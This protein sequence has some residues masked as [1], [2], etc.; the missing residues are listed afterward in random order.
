MAGS[1]YQSDLIKLY[2]AAFI[3]A[4]ERSGLDYW[5]GQLNSGKSFDS[6]LETVFSLDIV[7]SI[8]PEGLPNDS[9]VTL[10][11]VNVFGKAPDLEGLKYW[12]KQLANGQARGNLVMDMINT[13]LATVD[14]TPGK[15]YISNRL[16]VAEFAV[17][18]QNFQRADFTP[19]YLKSIMATVNADNSTVTSANAAMNSSVTGIGL[20]APLNAISI[21]VATNG[22]SQAE[23][24]AGV[25]VSVDLTGTNAVAGNTVELLIDQSSFSTPVTKVLTAA[26]VT[27]KKVSLT[28][29]GTNSWGSDGSKMLS[30]FVK[31]GK[32]GVGLAGG[33]IIVNLDQTAPRAPN[34][35]VTVAAATNGIS[36]TEKAAGVEV[37]VDLF[38]TNA[39]AGDKLELMLNG[40]TLVP[41][42]SLVL[43][44]SDIGNGSAKLLIAAST[45]WGAD[46][47]KTIGARLTDV[48]GNVGG[49]GGNL[50][51]VLDTTAPNAFKNTISIDAAAGGIGPLERDS[52]INVQVSLTGLPLVVGDSLE[53]LIDGRVFSQSTVKS[54]T[55][56]DI[57]AGKMNL[58]IGPGDTAWG[59]VDGDHVIS[60]RIIDAAGNQGVAGGDLKVTV[61]SQA[62][63]SQNLSVS[64]PSAANGLSSAEIAAGVDVVVSLTGSG[65][66]VGDLLTLYIDGSP[67]T[68][69]VSQALTAA[70][71]SAKAAILKV[72]NTINWGGDGVKKISANLRDAAGNLGPTSPALSVTID[73]VAPAK[74]AN[75]PTIAVAESN[76]NSAE[77]TAGVQVSVDITNTGALVGDQIE[78]LIDGKSFTSPVIQVLQANDV[79]TNKVTLTVS[80]A[81][82][83]IDG[84]KDI[85][86]RVIDV[87]GNTGTPSTPVNVMLDTVAPTG[88]STSLQ[89]PANAGGGLTPAERASG[90]VVTADLTGTGAV[91]GD[92]IEILIGGN[93]FA[94]PAKRVLTAAEI[95]AHLV[96]ITIGT[97]DGWIGTGSKDLT[98]RF[99]DTSGN[100]GS[101]AGKV[102]VNVLAPAAVSTALIVPAAIGGINPL[103]KATGVN[104]IVNLGNT[105]VQPG[106]AVE[107]LI[108]GKPFA[109]STLHVLSDTEIAVGSI[110]LTIAGGDAGWGSTDGDKSLSARIIDTFG[111]VGLGGGNQKVTVDSSSPSSQNLSLTMP[112]ALNGLNASEVAAGV[113]VTIGLTGTGVVAGD[114]VT[115][116]LGGSPFSSNVSLVLS[117][118]QVTAKSAV[119]TIPPTVNWGSDGNKILSAYITDAAGNQGLPGGSL[120]VVLDTSVPTAPQNPI[121]IP[122]AAQN[123]NSLE[124]LAGVSVIVDLT[125]SGAAAGDKLEVLIGGVP[126]ATPISQILS[127]ADINNHLANILIP[128]TAVWGSDGIKLISARVIDIAG[129]LGVPSP[130][131]S[132]NLDTTAPSSPAVQLQVPANAGGGIDPTERAAGVNVIVDLTGTL[133]TVGDTVEILNGGLPFT[134]PVTHV[135]TLND[136]ILRT[137]GLTIGTA[138]GW[139]SDGNKIL[140]I[141]FVDTSGNV[142]IPGGATT[143]NLDGTP[144]GMTATQLTVPAATNGINGTEITSGVV[145]NVDLNGTN[146]LAG[147]TVNILLNG[148]AFPTPVRQVLSSAQ[149]TAKTAAVTIP[150][151]AGWGA[152]GNKTLSASVTDVLGNVGAAGGAVIVLVDTVAPS[153]PTNSVSIPMAMNGISAAEKSSG[154][155]VL[156]DL[157]GTNAVVGDKLELLI[158]GSAFTSPVSVTLN[159]SHITNGVVNLTIPSTAGWGADASKTISARVIDFA[160]NVGIGG[161]GVTAILDTTAPNAPSSSL[162]VPANGGGGVTAAEKNAGI[163]V[164]VSLSGANVQAG[165]V[166]DVL[167]GGLPFTTPV[168]HVLTA[169]EVA[170]NSVTLNIGSG[171]GWGADGAKTLTARFTDVAG[172]V[173]A[174]GGS[175]TIT[176]LDTTPPNAPSLSLYVPSAVG[177]I[178]ASEK[179]AGVLVT[180]YLGGTFAL[181]GDSASLLIDGVAFA[182][183]VTH[184]LTSAEITAGSFNFTVPDVAGWGSDGLHILS[185]LVTDSSGNVGA[186]GGSVSVNLDTTAPLAPTN[187]VNVAVSSNGINATEKNAGVSVIVDLTGTNAVVN[188][189]VEIL[190]GGVSFTTPVVH[191]LTNPEI[192][193]HLAT[194]TIPTSAG[195]GSDG[196]KTLSA[197]VIDIAGNIGLSGGS[198]TSF[199]E[200]SV[201]AAAG[202]PAYTDTDGL[203]TI[204]AGDTYVFTISEATNKAL[205][206]GNI[207]VNNSHVLGTGATAVWSSDG[208]QLTLTLG[209]STTVAIGDT[210]SLVGVSDP[211]G[212][213]TNL[214]FSI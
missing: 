133:A 183:P 165:D 44:E 63:G 148:L 28:V 185:M 40:Q 65:A 121:A 201:P 99:T 134:T 131:L 164:T 74:P 82:W 149:I 155:A 114:V 60:A 66:V 140:S 13:G 90:V 160:G 119:V 14:G 47:T 182:S 69:N 93:P 21:P 49:V 189:V 27:A 105:N 186:P 167:L 94:T 89:V 33:D 85:S 150:A 87:A 214:S 88:P 20:G 176:I 135:L 120:T 2:L 181:A 18:Q 19:A 41:S 173:G 15:A 97:Q 57:S 92:T 132:V 170:D 37:V 31:D 144:P 77:K 200:T 26:D 207:T 172:N 50:N 22:I 145:V 61:D 59:T 209:A 184:L 78:L 104:V 177:S 70:Q 56:A 210:I 208:T 197:R 10:I 178:S 118:A 109:N 139:G 206:I 191:T 115:L 24:T 147:D 142:G 58:V 95:S 7:K 171:S 1:N 117:A 110:N 36:A 71:I 101:A 130:A 194:V 196:T 146:A 53:L 113:S 43:K 192:T 174:A 108:D 6:L 198:L 75:A 122:A 179:S 127:V 32:G 195:W 212:N 202:L 25:I 67:I 137:V 161:G 190:L 162:V 152:D 157:A 129:N 4:P 107:L 17:G 199:L 73:T 76:I 141:R 52:N 111:T 128:G 203:G 100:I 211:A 205:G 103:E 158:D 213:A 168:T 180:G 46:G 12:S 204:N 123:I 91:A 169:G 72:P 9:F 143:V 81:A 39:K 8:Y 35:I 16:A 29:A 187:V 23:V 125:G 80:A 30:V 42:A 96:S 153:A 151:S 163:D 64:I 51:L 112:A 126:F 193:A 86:A 68:P 54:V 106:D 188:D 84:A 11:Y 83:G 116:L 154:V 159:S 5:L 102:S 45:A 34:K 79:L 98:A 48:A 136:L 166:L 62:P 138:D 175:T 3:R 124:K 55:A 38:G 156:V